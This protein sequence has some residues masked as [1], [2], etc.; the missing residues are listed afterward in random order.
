[1]TTINIKISKTPDQDLVQLSGYTIYQ[2]PLKVRFPGLH[3]NNHIYKI[4][5]T[6]YGVMPS[7]LDAMTVQD[8]QTG[9]ISIIY[10]GTDPTQPADISTDV[11]L[12]LSSGTSQQ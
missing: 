11:S 1:M 2:Y 9:N 3:V 5:D 8:L 6:T 12:V 10:A 7:G 4:R